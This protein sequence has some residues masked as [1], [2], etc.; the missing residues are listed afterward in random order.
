VCGV[1]PALRAGATPHTKIKQAS[2]AGASKRLR[3]KAD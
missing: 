3:W 2:A 1:A